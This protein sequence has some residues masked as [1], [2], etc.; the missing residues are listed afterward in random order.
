VGTARR[1]GA[2]PWQ[3]SG[4]ANCSR[5]LAQ[6]GIRR[7]RGEPFVWPDLLVEIDQPPNA[8]EIDIEKELDLKWA[9]GTLDWHLH[10]PGGA[11]RHGRRAL[12]SN[13]ERLFIIPIAERDHCPTGLE[14][15]IFD[16]YFFAPRPWPIAGLTWRTL[17]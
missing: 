8:R 5:E 10:L 16:A 15:E 12:G 2:W 7:I 4:K 1:I 11:A 6:S 9:A 3:L 13:Y 17:S 14:R